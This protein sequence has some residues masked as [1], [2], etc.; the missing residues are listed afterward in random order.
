MEAWETRAQHMN[1][2][3]D[4]FGQAEADL[5]DFGILQKITIARVMAAL[6]AFTVKRRSYE[7]G[8]ETMPAPRKPWTRK[9]GV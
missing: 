4:S 9:G 3:L 2:L 1:E 8:E 6:Q 5:I 7:D